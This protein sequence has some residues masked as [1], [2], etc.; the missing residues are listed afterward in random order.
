MSELTFKFENTTVTINTHEIEG[1]TLYKAQDLLKGYGM[2]TKKCND[3]LRNWKNSKTVEFTVLKGRYGGTY[4]TK[5]QCLKLASYVSEDF[6]EAVY[7][8]FEAAASG[9]GNKAVDIATS[10][11]ITPEL[12]NKL[13]FWTPLLHKEITAWSARNRKGK[14]GYTMIY[15]HIVNKVVT[16]IYTKELKKSHSISS[17]KDYLIKQ[18]HVEGLG[19]YIAMC[20]LLVPLLQANSDYELLKSVFVETPKLYKAA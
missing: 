10:K 19:A 5:R 14:F 11:V 12:L 18:N 17:M 13:N 15:N 2:D 9:D 6:E 1:Q 16:N 7:E 8:A 3:T 4:L 20:E